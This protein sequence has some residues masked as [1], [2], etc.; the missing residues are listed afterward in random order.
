MAT[1]VI[2]EA[3]RLPEWKKRDT[4]AAEQQEG[5]FGE[6]RDPFVW[7][8]GDTCFMLVGSGDADNG[9]G[10]AILYSSEDLYSWQSHGFLLDYSYE[11]NREL[12]HVFE[13]P[14]LLPLRDESGEAA[15]HIFIM[16]ACQIEGS[17]VENYAFLGRWEP[18]QRSFHKLHEKPIL[19]RRGGCG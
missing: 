18:K 6:F 11:E 9:G 8:E 7:L 5:W 14:V 1:A 2:D 16:C 15:C 4:P 10:N 13:L 19:P 3:R 12:G 17:A